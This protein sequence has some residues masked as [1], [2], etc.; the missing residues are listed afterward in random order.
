MSGED[1]AGIIRRIGE[2]GPGTATPP[3]FYGANAHL[4]R[5]MG[6]PVFIDGDTGQLVTVAITEA[7][8]GVVEDLIAVVRA[9]Q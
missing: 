2:Q 8:R 5:E 1:V 9:D 7:I 6:I 3:I 4:A